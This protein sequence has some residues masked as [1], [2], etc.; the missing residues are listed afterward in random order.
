MK[1]FIRKNKSGNKAHNNKTED[2]ATLLCA[3]FW[4]SLF[5]GLFKGQ[6]LTLIWWKSQKSYKIIC[7]YLK[8]LLI[9]SSCLKKL[10]LV[11]NPNL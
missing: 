5:P 7:N 2:I 6:I 10:K 11:T 1:C 9:Q 8:K 3:D 4:H